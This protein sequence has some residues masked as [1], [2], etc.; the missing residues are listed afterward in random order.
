MKLNL[1]AWRTLARLGYA[2]S[3]EKDRPI[4]NGIEFSLS[5]KL[6]SGVATDSFIL[7]TNHV[8]IDRDL[9][10]PEEWV[11]VIPARQAL[12]VEKD[13][14]SLER[15]RSKKDHPDASLLLQ[16]RISDEAV[17]VSLDEDGSL[18]DTDSITRRIELIEGTFPDSTGLI[19]DNPEPGEPEFRFNPD[20]VT[21]L[22]KTVDEDDWP[23]RFR[24]PPGRK[25]I[26]ATALDENWRG[27]LM[28]VA[29]T[30]RE[31]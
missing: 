17:E 11:G 1:A 7:A 3:A 25:P 21:R 5:R 2:A 14:R 31:S 15:Y 30:V 10:D 29:I 12:L 20:L 22:G 8:E 28:P 27:L 24:I 6:L 18:F 9:D 23:V 4:L 13:V 19:I 26:Q 16:V